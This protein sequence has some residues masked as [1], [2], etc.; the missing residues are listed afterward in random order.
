MID[1]INCVRQNSAKAFPRENRFGVIDFIAAPQCA[2]SLRLLAH[3][4]HTYICTRFG[5]KNDDTR[6]K[7]TYIYRTAIAIIILFARV[8]VLFACYV[9]NSLIVCSLGFT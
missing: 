4:I 6:Q 1:Q 2:R 5:Y 9:R 8:Q 7:Y 3:I